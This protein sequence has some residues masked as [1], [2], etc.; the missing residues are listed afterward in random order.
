MFIDTHC[1]LSMMVKRDINSKLE[2]NLT[3]SIKMILSDAQQAQ[4]GKIITIATNLPDTIN[5]IEIA[6]KFP[7]VFATV[8]IHPCD[9][10]ESWRTEF[11]TIKTLVQKKEENKIVGIGETDLDFY[12]KPFFK[13][14]QIDAFKFH[15]ELAIEHDLPLIIHIRESI[16][17]VLK[18][19]EQYKKDARGVVHCFVQSKDVAHSLI[20]WGYTLGIGGPLTYPKNEG[21]RELVR[22]IPLEH[23][24]LETDAP[25]LPPQQYRGKQ[26]HP[27]YIPLIARAIANIKDVGVDVVEEV[28]TK[29]VE[30][31]FGI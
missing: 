20:Q 10:T 9:C 5:N 8:G 26:N 1:H 25:F 7:C 27:K 22:N 14:R 19:L 28:T 21:L 4:V 13:Q 3:E 23:I 6:Q 17:E 16:D 29:N 2:N 24:V 12:H 30:R 15:I 11:E 18:I 31:I